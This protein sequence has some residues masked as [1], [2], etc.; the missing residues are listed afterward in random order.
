MLSRLEMFSGLVVGSALM[1]TSGSEELSV[2]SWW[3]LA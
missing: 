2:E 3:I 1:Q